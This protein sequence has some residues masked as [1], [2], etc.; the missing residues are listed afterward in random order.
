MKKDIPR[1]FRAKRLHKFKDE[2][3]YGNIRPLINSVFIYDTNFSVRVDPDTVQ[4]LSGYDKDGNEI[5]RTYKLKAV[6]EA[7]GVVQYSL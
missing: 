2:I 4:K 1:K 7:K 6:E 5:Y 3:V